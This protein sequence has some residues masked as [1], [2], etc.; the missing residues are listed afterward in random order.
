MK[1]YFNWLSIHIELKKNK[2]HEKW[3]KNARENGPGK[4]NCEQILNTLSIY[5]IQLLEVLE[6]KVDL[7]LFFFLTKN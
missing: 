7:L 6:Y 4:V 2:T 1:L 3:K 5:G